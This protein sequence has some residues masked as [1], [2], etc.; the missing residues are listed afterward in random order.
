METKLRLSLIMKPLTDATFRMF[1]SKLIIMI[2]VCLIAAKS[3]L[4]GKW[5][6]GFEV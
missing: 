2:K 5:E 4:Q 3:T 6:V 1:P